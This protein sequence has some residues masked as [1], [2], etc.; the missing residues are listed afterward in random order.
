MTQSLTRNP[1]IV[2]TFRVIRG[3]GRVAVYFLEVRLHVAF[4]IFARY[5]HS[6]FYARE[7]FVSICLHL[8]FPRKGSA[9][10]NNRRKRNRN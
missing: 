6:F 3:F 4:Q 9:Q 5:L 1:V 2:S 8:E 10:Q 7:F